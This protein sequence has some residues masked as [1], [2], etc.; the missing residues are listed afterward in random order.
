MDFSLDALEYYR[1]KDLLVR[2][3][4]TT[5]ARHALDE[6]EPI[7]DSEKLADEHAITAEA[8]EYLREHRVPY[9]DIALLPQAI[10]K[11]TVAGSVLE[12]SEIEAIQAFL[13]HTEGLRVR[14][15]EDREGFPKLAQKAQRL[16]DLRDL[17]KQLGRAIQNGEIDENYSPELRRIRRALA[18]ARSRLT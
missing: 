3:V 15:K 2:Y 11:L 18:A 10:E 14:W 17:I 7:L 16:P 8:M 9:N 5:A 1:L 13:V 6:L 4:S 12:I